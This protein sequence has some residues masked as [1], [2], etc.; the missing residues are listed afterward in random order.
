[1]A[2]NNPKM[3]ACKLNHE[4]DTKTDRIRIKFSLVST[5]KRNL[6]YADYISYRAVIP[7]TKKIAC[8][9]CRLMRYRP[10]WVI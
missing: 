10:S 8:L 2:L 9:F 7:L 6:G 3:F 5:C 1:M 4:T